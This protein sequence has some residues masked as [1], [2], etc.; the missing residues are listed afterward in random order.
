MLSALVASG[1]PTD[2]FI[3]EG[4]FPKKKGRSKRF[5]KLT[6]EERTIIIFESPERLRRTLKDCCNYLGDRPVVI[7]RELTK[8]HEELWRGKLSES[9]TEFMSRKARGEVTIIIGKD[10][11]KIHFKSGVEE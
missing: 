5:E 4:F 3:F 6:N 8:V 10:S 2:R 9:V 7:C 11:E 1:L